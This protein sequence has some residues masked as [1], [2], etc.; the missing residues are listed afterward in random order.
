[1]AAKRPRSALGRVLNVRFHLNWQWPAIKMQYE[2]LIQRSNLPPERRLYEHMLMV[3][4]MD[5]F[6]IMVRRFLR[7]AEQAR[8][9]PSEYQIDVKRAI[10]V[11]NSRW[12]NIIRVRDALEHFDK[13]GMFPVPAGA[14]PTSGQGDAEFTF[15][16]PGGNLEISKLYEDARSILQAILR[17]IEPIE[18]EAQH[19]IKAQE[20]SQQVETKNGS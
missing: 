11:F 13:A 20:D 10:G 15:L 17:V 6:V 1:M 3:A 14:Y 5:F 16:W 18:A 4:D 7:T 8:Q 19:L 9:I 12:K 2:R